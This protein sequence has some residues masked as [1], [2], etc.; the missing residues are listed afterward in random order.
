MNN[1]MAIRKSICQIHKC[2]YWKKSK[3]CKSFWCTLMKLY[4][5]RWKHIDISALARTEVKATVP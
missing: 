2:K 3:Y 1:L 4:T 5:E